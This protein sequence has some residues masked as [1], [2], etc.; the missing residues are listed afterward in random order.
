MEETRERAKRFVAMAFLE[1]DIE[2]R[3]QALGIA[4]SIDPTLYLAWYEYGGAWYSKAEYHRAINCYDEAL[5]LA[6]SSKDRVGC[7]CSKGEALE[8]LGKYEEAISCYNEAATIDSETRQS[9]THQISKGMRLRGYRG[10]VRIGG[11]EA[12]RS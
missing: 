8:E 5:G 1:T 4:T 3:L 6:S 9:L 12:P 7:L 11:K 10:T 2:K